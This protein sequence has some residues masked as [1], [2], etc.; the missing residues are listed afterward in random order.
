MRAVLICERVGVAG[1]GAD[2]D[3]DIVLR[4]KDGEHFLFYHRG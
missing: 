2:L 3:I 4:V 1:E